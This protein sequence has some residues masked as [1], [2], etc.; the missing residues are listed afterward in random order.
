MQTKTD[1]LAKHPRAT[2]ASAA[3]D[4]FGAT[5]IVSEKGVGPLTS[6]W[7]PYE[8]WRTRVKPT[9]GDSSREIALGH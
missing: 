6:G 7:D 5:T 1:S 4:D 9:Q 2:A 8:V 3:N